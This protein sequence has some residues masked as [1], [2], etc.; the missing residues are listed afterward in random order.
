[1]MSIKKGAFFDGNKKA[2]SLPRRLDNDAAGGAQNHRQQVR[3][4]RE[5]FLP[6]GNYLQEPFMQER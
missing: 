4:L 1:M 3:L 2:N 6:Q 5:L